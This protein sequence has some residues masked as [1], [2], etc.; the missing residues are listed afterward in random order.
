MTEQ[1]APLLTPSAW[2][3]L[4]S[5]AAGVGGV[6]KQ[7][8]E[9]FLVEEIPAYLPCGEG[10]HL[11]L[12]VEK[13]N[14]S[15]EMLL[16]QL[17]KQLSVPRSEIGMAGLKD[18]QAVTR[19]WV[20]VPAR[21][22][23]LVPALESDDLQVLEARRH[24]NKLK[25]G[26]LKGNRFVA[27]LRGVEPDHA[28][29]DAIA[30]QLQSQ[31]C[32]NYFGMQRF[33]H[34]HST[35]TLGWQLLLGQILPQ[36]IPAPRRKFLLRLALSA[37]QSG[38]FN[39][40]L[41][42]RL[43][44]GLFSTVLCGDLMEILPAGAKFLVTEAAADQPRFDS[45]EISTTGPIFGVRMR[46]P[47]GEVHARELAILQKSGLT[48]EHF[49][50]FSSLMEGT[51]RPFRFLPAG[52][53]CELLPTNSS[54]HETPRGDLRV[55]V[56]LPAGAYLTVL[57]HEFQKSPLG[58]AESPDSAANSEDADEIASQSAD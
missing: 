20:S 9:D 47:G 45:W 4:T 5:Q 6:W 15:S 2:P 50:K 11:F 31:G 57:L 55:S 7:S 44:D 51:R 19:Q 46:S 29:I 22:E 17:S 54:A 43:R 52:L 10:E 26:H 37:V 56:E 23:K 1:T 34:Q 58:V 49:Q 53:T 25:T 36:D 21:A 42:Q 48:I 39:E 12:W 38:L 14:L 35:W 8:P 27:I 13:R 16:A 41:A 24:R 40:V 3:E 33:G 30:R 18:K 28:K 32:P